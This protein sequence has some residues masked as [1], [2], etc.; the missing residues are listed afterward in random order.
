MS[1]IRNYR[2]VLSSAEVNNSARGKGV[3]CVLVMAALT[4]ASLVLSFA[5]HAEDAQPVRR[6]AIDSVA[7]GDP[8]RIVCLRFYH[9]GML[10]RTPVCNTARY[11]AAEYERNKNELREDQMRALM[12]SHRP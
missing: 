1:E 4:G 3:P 11:W 12:S 9:E 10:I 8:N 7:F 2:G 6:A 5:A